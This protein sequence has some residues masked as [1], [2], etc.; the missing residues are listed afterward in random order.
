MGM[1]LVFSGDM[2][3]DRFK[4][5]RTGVTLKQRAVEDF[6][7]GLT[8]VLQRVGVLA[9]PRPTTARSE[10]GLRSNQA[11]VTMRAADKQ[12]EEEQRACIMFEGREVCGP[13]RFEDGITCVSTASAGCALELRALNFCAKSPTTATWSGGVCLPSKAGFN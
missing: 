13:A 10:L 5:A 9:Q 11:A 6:Q 1:L 4:R 8:R 2:G 3:K 7:R 12:E